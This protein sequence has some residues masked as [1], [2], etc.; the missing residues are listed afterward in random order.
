M[1]GIWAEIGERI[2]E[3]RREKRY[4]Q[5]DTGDL[6]NL[7]E[8]AYRRREDGKRCFTVDHI[9]TMC[10]MFFVSPDWILTGKRE[11]TINSK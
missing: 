6:L 11:P 2:W 4:T 7:S 8:S 9:L 1:N 3:K 5:K 10:T